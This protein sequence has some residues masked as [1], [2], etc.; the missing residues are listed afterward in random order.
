MKQ[1]VRINSHVIE[2]EEDGT[3]LYR[4]IGH[5][6]LEDAK[7]V[8]AQVGRWTKPGEPVFFLADHTKTGGLAPEVRKFYADSGMLE[9]QTTHVAIYGDTFQTRVMANMVT[10]AM[11]VFGRPVN[12]K[13]FKDEASARAFLK[14]QRNAQKAR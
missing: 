13:F 14:E 6:S 11:A 8:V 1:V 12:A 4:E 7:E 3:I 10:A 2:L 9:G 5:T